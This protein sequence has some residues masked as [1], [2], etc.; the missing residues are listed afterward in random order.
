ME[1]LKRYYRTARLI[2]VVMIGSLLIYAVVVE[3]FRS[4]GLPIKDLSSL[5]NLE[6]VRYLFLGIAVVQF[7]VIRWI[8]VR[9][10]SKKRQS[11]ILLSATIVTYALCESVALFGLIL[12]FL[13]GSLFDF[14][15]FLS[16][17]LIY[18]YV[19]FPRYAQWEEWM[20]A[21]LP[22]GSGRPEDSRIGF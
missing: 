17:S 22:D 4:T 9:L 7:F 2:G 3:V 6:I 19:F 13:S 21:R 18:F 12:F 5:L 1:E 20:N 8:R 15:L 14:Y 11:Q 16:L 10:L